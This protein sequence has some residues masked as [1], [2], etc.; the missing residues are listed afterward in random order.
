MAALHVLADRDE[1][2]REMAVF[3]REPPTV[4]NDDVVAAAARIPLGDDDVAL[5]GGRDGRSGRNADVDPGV[6]DEGV[7]D[8]VDAHPERRGDRTA[9]R[10][11]E[12]TWRTRN[13]RHRFA[14]EH[15]R[16]AFRGQPFFLFA[17][18]LANQRFQR[19]FGVGRL[20]IELRYFLRDLTA[21]RVGDGQELRALIGQ[22]R[23]RELRLLLR[24]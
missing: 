23:E 6:Q 2:L 13:R 22:A 9:E 19:G 20:F 17:L 16:A 15:P 14:G 7:G 10:P 3:G 11:R 4:R 1:K 18:L 21:L 12:G 24:L 8:R 5:G